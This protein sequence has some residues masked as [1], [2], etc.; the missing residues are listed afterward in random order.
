MRWATPVI[1]M[2]RTATRA[3]TL[4]GRPIGEGDKLLL[5]YN[6]ANRDEDVFADP[7]GSTCAGPPTITSGSAGPARTTASALTWRGARSR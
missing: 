4:G 1:W 6:S 7:F 2:R 3:T 5:F